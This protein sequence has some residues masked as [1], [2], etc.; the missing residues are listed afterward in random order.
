MGIEPQLMP[1]GLTCPVKE[2]DQSHDF[3]GPKFDVKN[4]PVRIEAFSTHT[5][6]YPAVE[7]GDLKT[8]A[9][10]TLPQPVG[11]TT[12]KQTADFC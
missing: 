1:E 6:S 8:L 3:D 7:I 2:Q 10:S 5:I 9:T 4:D 12:V 11:Y